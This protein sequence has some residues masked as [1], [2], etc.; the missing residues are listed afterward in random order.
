M[1]V[2]LRT[3]PSVL[4]EA[5]E[6]IRLNAANGEQGRKSFSFVEWFSSS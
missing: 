5:L 1:A 4:L 2:E 3:Q 6:K